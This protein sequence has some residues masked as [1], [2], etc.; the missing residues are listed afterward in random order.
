MMPQYILQMVCANM[1]QTIF[2]MQFVA[3]LR[4]HTL[5]SYFY[6]FIFARTFAAII[7]FRLLL[8]VFYKLRYVQRT[9]EMLIAVPIQNFQRIVDLARFPARLR[10]YGVLPKK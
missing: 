4:C 10:L 1:A 3:L 5:L 7:H 9:T 8:Y 6:Q 2:F